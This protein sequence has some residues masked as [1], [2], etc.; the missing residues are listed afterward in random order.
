MREKHHN[1]KSYVPVSL[2]DNL[3]PKTYYLDRVDEKY[4]RFYK[5]K[6]NEVT[7]INGEI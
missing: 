3:F 1:A 2:V 7:I 5:R 4:R 6:V